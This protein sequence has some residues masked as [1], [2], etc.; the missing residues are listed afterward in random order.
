MDCQVKINGTPV[1]GN[2]TPW[3]TLPDLLIDLED[4]RFVGLTFQLA[5]PQFWSAMKAISAKLD[6]RVLR[7]N[8]ITT[9]EAIQM[10]PGESGKAHRL[11][12]TWATAERLGCEWAS[13]TC[14]QWFWWYAKTGSWGI[15]PPIV[16]LGLT[17][18][19]MILDGHELV[20]PAYLGFPL[21]TVEYC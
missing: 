7:Y 21:L 3:V 13:L 11:E 1:E 19:D 14:G 4:R 18:I 8:E 12:V 16:G 17:D 5:R 10:Y 20:F 2:D 9:P 15:S 6:P